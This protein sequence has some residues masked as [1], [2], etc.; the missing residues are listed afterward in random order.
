MPKLSL[1]RLIVTAAFI[2]SLA[3]VVILN[4]RA[5]GSASR[6]A[7]TILL[8]DVAHSSGIDFVHQE[9]T[10]EDAGPRGRGGE[11]YGMHG[12]AFRSALTNGAPGDPYACRPTVTPVGSAHMRT[13]VMGLTSSR[14]VTVPGTLP[15]RPAPP[16]TH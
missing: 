7:A 1:R 9:V 10:L 3:S 11:T 12:F 5:S 13:A 4:A 8:S 6:A 2:A 14:A 15:A 16:P